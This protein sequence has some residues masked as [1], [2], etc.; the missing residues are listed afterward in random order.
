MVSLSSSC[1]IPAMR[2]DTHAKRLKLPAAVQ[3]KRHSGGASAS[4]EGGDIDAALGQ[5]THKQ[6]SRCDTLVVQPAACLVH[7]RST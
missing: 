3:L 1:S 2:T 5:E 4:D 7:V 6:L